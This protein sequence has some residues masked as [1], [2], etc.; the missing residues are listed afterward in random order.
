MK[1]GQLRLSIMKSKKYL[2]K[3]N[4]ASEISGTPHN[5]PCII[6]IPGRQDSKKGAEKQ[7]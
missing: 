7:S 6:G 4:R 3:T 1:T 2:K 5:I